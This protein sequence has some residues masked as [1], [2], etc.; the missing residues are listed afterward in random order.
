MAQKVLNEI[1]MREYVEREVRKALMNENIN[2]GLDEG[3]LDFIAGKLF[4]GGGNPNS[5]LGK[6]IKSHMNFPDMMNLVLGIFGVAPIVKWL[7][8]ALGIDVNGP[9]GN[10]IV[11]ALSGFGTVAVGDAIQAKRGVSENKMKQ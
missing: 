6:L 10:M 8:G 3:V 5:P 11:T 9:F 2:E 7:C 4:N 1:Q